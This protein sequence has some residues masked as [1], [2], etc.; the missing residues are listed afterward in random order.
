VDKK[1]TVLA[2]SWER[3]SPWKEGGGDWVE[4]KVEM[5]L[6]TEFKAGLA[7]GVVAVLGTG[8]AFGEVAGKCGRWN[9]SDHRLLRRLAGFG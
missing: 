6:P 9:E 1:M 7:E 8:V 2:P 3:V 5:I 4:T